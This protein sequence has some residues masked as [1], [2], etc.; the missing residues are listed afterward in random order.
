MPRGNQ[1]AVAK[2]MH[3][4]V[5][6]TAQPPVCP[7]WLGVVMVVVPC[8]WSCACP[9]AAP[10]WCFMPVVPARPCP[11]GRSEHQAQQQHQ[12]KKAGTVLSKPRQQ[13]HEGCTARPGGQ[14]EHVLGV[15]GQQTI[16]G[17]GQP[18]SQCQRP[19]SDQNCYQ[20][21][22]VLRIFHEGLTP[23]STNQFS[24]KPPQRR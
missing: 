4:V 3:A 23:H 1:H 13:V 16:S 8:A 17:R 21:H 14:T 12:N 20:N 19:G 18:P 6:R 7:G 9:G 11:A 24:S 2:A 5:A 22:S 10:W 15:A